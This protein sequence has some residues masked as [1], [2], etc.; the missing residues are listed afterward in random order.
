MPQVTGDELIAFLRKRRFVILRQTG[1]HVLLLGPDGNQV[2]VPLH[3]CKDLGRGIA[4]RVLKDAG[5]SV[6]DFIRLK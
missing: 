4:I 3:R 5:Y 2:V 6:D 1:S